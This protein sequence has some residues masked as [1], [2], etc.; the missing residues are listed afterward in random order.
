MR[1]EEVKRLVELAVVENELVEVALVA[2]NCWKFDISVV[3]V[4]INEDAV[5]VP[6]TDNF[7]FGVVE[8]IPTLP[9]IRA[10]MAVRAPALGLIVMALPDGASKN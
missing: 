8:L 9:P 6:A 7:Q 10:V 2:K 4:A 1:A 5:V 3:D